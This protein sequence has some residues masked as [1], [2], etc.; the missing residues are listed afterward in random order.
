MGLYSSTL[1]S[2]MLL[3]GGIMDGLFMLCAQPSTG[4]HI[5]TTLTTDLC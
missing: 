5:H 3:V 1:V 4:I 2:G